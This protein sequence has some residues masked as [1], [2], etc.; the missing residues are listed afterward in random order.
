[1]FV[2]FILHLYFMSFCHYHFYELKIVITVILNDILYAT[3]CNPYIPISSLLYRVFMVYLFLSEL[4]YYMTPP[5]YSEV[6]F[7]PDVS[8]I[9]IATYVQRLVVLWPDPYST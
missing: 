1:M 3:L 2:L 9:H 4:Y 8:F 6:Q 7:L 5:L